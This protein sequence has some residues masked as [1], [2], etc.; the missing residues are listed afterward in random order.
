MGKTLAGLALM[1]GLAIG[2]VGCATPPR[3]AIINLSSD[4][5]GATIYQNSFKLGVCPGVNKYLISPEEVQRGVK[6][7]D[8]L[9]FIWKSGAKKTHTPRLNLSGTRGNPIYNISVRRPE[10]HPRIEIDIA[11]EMHIQELLLRN[12]EVKA[13]ERS[14]VANEERAIVEK[15]RNSREKY[16]DFINTVNLLNQQLQNNSVITGD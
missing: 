12:R 5:E 1:A 15:E 13:M 9:K 11:Y 3:Y 7:C 16:W 10:D 6:E 4:P 8:E 2:A 14:A